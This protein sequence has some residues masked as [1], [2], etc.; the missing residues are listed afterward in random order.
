[1]TG[2]RFFAVPPIYQHRVLFW[3]IVGALV[4]RGAMIAVGAQLIQRFT[5]IIYV[6]GA[7]LILTG[8]KPTRR[9]PPA[10]PR[11]WTAWST[12]PGPAPSSPLRSSWRW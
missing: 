4:M 8:I 1:M 2:H 11:R 6:F 12:R 10:P 9:P 5:W 7:F 3:G